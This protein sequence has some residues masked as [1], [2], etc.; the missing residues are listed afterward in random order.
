MPLYTVV[1]TPDGPGSPAGPTGQ[2]T[3][4]VETAA[5]APRITEL[6]IRT[7][8]PRGLTPVGL[9]GMDLEAVVRVLASAMG[10]GTE[11]T[12]QPRTPATV[13]EAAARAPEVAAPRHRVSAKA[14]SA[15]RTDAGA[16][17]ERM[18]RRMPDRE[19]LLAVHQELGSVTAV[20]RHYEVPRHTAQGWMSRARKN[21]S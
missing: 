2:A 3:I 9:S 4:V 7:S 17:P 1:I 5:P 15:P 19:E 21:S 18:Y 13:T 8:D 16:E 6:T 11:D 20:A 12:A 10:I 14:V